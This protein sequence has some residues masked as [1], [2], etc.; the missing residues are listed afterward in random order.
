MERLKTKSE[1]K[2]CWM[3]KAKTRNHKK[4]KQKRKRTG[5]TPSDEVVLHLLPAFG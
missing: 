4:A 5:V 2:A 1:Q 3:Q